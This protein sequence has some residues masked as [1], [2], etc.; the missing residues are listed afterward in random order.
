MSDRPT[1]SWT[2]SAIVL[3]LVLALVS[4][5]WIE[6]DTYR[7][8]GGLLFI[9]GF[10][11][12]LQDGRKA[13][14]GWMG[15]LCFGWVAYVAARMAWTYATDDSGERL[16]TSEGIYLFPAAY[17]TIGYAL[18]RHPQTLAR[19]SFIFIAISVVVLVST[20]PI[21]GAFDGARHDFLLTNNTIHSS[22]CG[23]FIVFA[24]LSFAGFVWRRGD[25]V[26]AARL[27]L[28][29]AYIAVLL[30]AIGIYAAKSK[31]VWFA[32]GVGIFVQLLML[33]G[34]KLH[35]RGF[36]AGAAMLA[37]FAVFIAA[38]RH[39]IWA[40]LGP[41]VEAAFG[42]VSRAWQ[43]GTLAGAIQ[44]A[45]ASGTIPLGMTER[46]MLWSN[47]V[48][49]WALHPLLGNGIAW[50]QAFYRAHYGDPGYNLLHN[51]YLE[52]AVRYGLAGLVFYA[53]LFAWSLV[54]S[55]RAARRGLI[56]RE[57]FVFHSVSMA[58][59]LATILTNSNSRLAIGETY[60]MANA[61]FGFCCFFLLQRSALGMEAPHG[62]PSPDARA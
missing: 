55:H 51:G 16:G 36:A 49:T 11:A 7:Y 17:S 26:P 22:V 23:G 31:G 54:Q 2:Q 4:A 28:A 19:A 40:S 59:F 12:Y 21:I 58:F 6:R 15:A 41:S 57:A 62:R 60:I 45:I 56:A 35:G 53:L 61:A 42:I 46:L 48:E 5:V 33:R 43:S 37:A 52:I 29:T 44:D 25:A 9:Y 10:A 50:E 8:A 32:M 24:S 13:T 3:L 1:T 18:A 20:V 30:C 38:D 27:W 39:D 47:A 34:G 14:V